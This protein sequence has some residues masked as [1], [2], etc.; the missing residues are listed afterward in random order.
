MRLGVARFGLSTTR[1]IIIISAFISVYFGFTI[2]GN[3][4]HQYEL[5]RQNADLEQQITVDQ[6]QL[7]R[8]QALQQWMESDSFIEAM[9]RKQGLVMPGDHPILVAAPAATPAPDQNSGEWW[10]RYFEQ[11]AGGQ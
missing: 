3:R 5:D 9:A 1:L 6:S 4:V 10:E 7:A 2:V 11:P 8:L